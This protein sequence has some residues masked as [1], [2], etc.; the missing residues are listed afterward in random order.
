MLLVI[1]WNWADSE[2][3]GDEQERGH[4]EDVRDFYIPHRGLLAFLLRQ[5][6]LEI[7]QQF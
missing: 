2:N 3:A 1:L 5:S 4:L 7:K 6:F